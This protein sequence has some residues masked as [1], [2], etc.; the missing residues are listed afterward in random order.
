MNRDVGKRD[1]PFRVSLPLPPQRQKPTEQ[2]QD[3]VTQ[4]EAL[5]ATLQTGRVDGMCT[6]ANDASHRSRIRQAP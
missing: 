2:P 4:G 3:V 1:W 5:A 6:V